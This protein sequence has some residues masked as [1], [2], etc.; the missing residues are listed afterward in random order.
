[1]YDGVVEPFCISSCVLGTERH[2]LVSFDGFSTIS[3]PP[4]DIWFLAGSLDPAGPM[5]LDS[6]AK[7]GGIDLPVAPPQKWIFMMNSLTTGSVMWSQVLPTGVYK[8]FVRSL[9]NSVN[10]TMDRLPRAFFCITTF[11]HSA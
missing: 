7:L 10:Q 6:L 2:M 8:D 11:L 5:S 4:L 9:I 3:K 1:M